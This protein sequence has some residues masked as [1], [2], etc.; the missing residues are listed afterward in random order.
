MVAMSVYDDG[1]MLVVT[2]LPGCEDLDLSWD[3]QQVRADEEADGETW[4]DWGYNADGE[5]FGED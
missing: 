2:V 5:T 4:E 1:L 3:V